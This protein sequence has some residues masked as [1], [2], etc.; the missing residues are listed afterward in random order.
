MKYPLKNINCTSLANAES[1]SQ[2]NMLI[3]TDNLPERNLITTMKFFHTR[4]QFV[5][6]TLIKLF[7]NIKDP[8]KHILLYKDMY[9]ETLNT[10]KELGS[11][12]ED[13]HNAEDLSK[14]Y[15]DL[16]QKLHQLD[17]KWECVDKFQKQSVQ[18]TK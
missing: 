1:K 16:L 8:K 4:L 11:S 18:K 9:L 10:S 7:T 13:V 5:L 15:Y 3:V 12:E 17:Y 14:R 6:R 2:K